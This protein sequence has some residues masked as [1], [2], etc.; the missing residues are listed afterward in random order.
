MRKLRHQ[1]IKPFARLNVVELRFEPVE[2]ALCSAWSCWVSWGLVPTA[3]AAV[4][5]G[6]L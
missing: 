6:V 2:L 4:W 1:R 5:G 3:A